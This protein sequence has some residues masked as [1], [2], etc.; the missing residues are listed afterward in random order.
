MN[1]VIYC[2]VS[3]RDQVDGT[4]LESHELACRDYA[5]RNKLNVL[6]VFIEEGESAKVAQRTKLMEL[7]E[8][9][10]T[11][12]R[13]VRVL[14]VW[15]LDRFARNIEDH[16]SV[17]ALLRR[18]GVEI[19]SV[20][21]PIQSDP[22]GKLMEAILAGYAQFDN[23][24]RSV[25]TIQGM[26][27]R[28]REGICPWLPPLG[29][30]PPKNGKKTEP[31][32]PDPRCFELLK[33]GWQLYATGLFSKAAVLRRLQEWGVEGY[34]RSP[35]S[36]QTLSRV[37]RNPYY[38]GI[39]RDP[40]SGEEYEGRHVA[41]VSKADF[42]RVQE[43]LDDRG[44][45]QP[46]TV[47][48][49]S[50]PARGYVRC[51]GCLGR[52]TAAYTKGRRKRYPYYR[53]KRPQCPIGTKSYA[54]ADVHD[55]VSQRLS[56]LAVPTNRRARLAA[57]IGA[58]FQAATECSHEELVR[59][60]Q[61][62]KVEGQLRELVS[63]RAS[64]LIN[65]QQFEEQR[66]ALQQRLWSLRAAEPLNDVEPLTPEEI[67]VWVQSWSGIEKLWRTL[68]LE[69]RH[70]LL[71]LVFP[72]GYVHEQS[73]TAE[74]GLVFRTFRSSSDGN[75]RLVRLTREKANTLITQ[76]RRF[77]AAVQAKDPPEKKAA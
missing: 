8:Y 35:L 72:N 49:Q 69:S 9:C 34:R 70:Q 42:A 11:K 23:D 67:E 41:M 39:L 65:D 31:D 77:L 64:R 26:R 47:L 68:P 52:M 20:T 1:A 14:L 19:V 73:R 54:A 6:D 66:E 48:H 43:L 74:L 56:E 60:S 40:W 13:D 55:E 5:R 75:P 51:P 10:K 50:F 29:Y 71:G 76:V 59:Q 57:K 3:S 7:L 38:A 25:R 4:S 58:V 45:S 24:I 18:S 21:E 27:Q 44:N 15:K 33:K 22:T 30:L 53:C 2:R 62:S 36:E 37:F 61:V 28:L 12:D 63:M 32:A 17:K 46:H 16:Y